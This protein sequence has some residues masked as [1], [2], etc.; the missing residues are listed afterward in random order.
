VDE[1]VKVAGKPRQTE[2][3]EQPESPKPENLTFLADLLQICFPDMPRT[4][5]DAMA[6]S[7]LLSEVLG[8]VCAQQVCFVSNHAQSDFVVV[9]LC[10]LVLSTIERL[11]QIIATRA[12]YRQAIQQSGLQWPLVELE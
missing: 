7:E 8:I 6:G 2:E 4:T 1:I 5:A 10:G 11:N 9:V 12:I 3:K